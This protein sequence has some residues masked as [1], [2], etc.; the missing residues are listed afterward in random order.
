MASVKTLPILKE[1]FVELALG[2][3]LLRTFVILINWEVVYV[4]T[5]IC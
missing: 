4:I 1:E 2:R 5:T 3:S